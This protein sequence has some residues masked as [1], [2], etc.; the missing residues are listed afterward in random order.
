MHCL[1]KSSSYRVL[2]LFAFN[3]IPQR[4]HH[5]LTF[6]SSRLR[7]SAIVTPTPR[8]DTTAIKVESSVQPINLFYR[9]EKKSELYRRKNNGPKTL[10]CGTPDKTLISYSDKDTS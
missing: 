4:S 2:V 3:F 9:M 5:S 8:D 7:N 1:T 10:P 6:T